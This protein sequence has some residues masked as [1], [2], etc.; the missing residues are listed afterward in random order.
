MI[1]ADPADLSWIERWGL[2][3]HG[4]RSRREAE[5]V[6]A[7]WQE[8]L[9]ALG[10]DATIASLGLGHTHSG[11][12]AHRFLI[13]VDPVFE[14]SSL[15]LYGRKFAQL[16]HLPEQARPDTPI[17]HRLPHRY[18]EV[19]RRGCTRARHD[20]APVRLEG[21][22][23]RYGGRIEQYRA[24][25]IPF[26]VKPDSLTSFTFGAFNSRIVDADATS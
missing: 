26:G 21:E 18:L 17:L 13:A 16:L 15:L 12:W 8:R 6:I 19:F 10:D 14:R 4:G 5:R 1:I 22:I 25:F 23:K 9:A 7:Y 20:M 2:D 3:H 24:V 11:E